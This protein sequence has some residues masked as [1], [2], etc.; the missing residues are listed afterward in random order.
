M[1]FDNGSD[2][3]QGNAASPRPTSPNEEVWCA[4]EISEQMILLVRDRGYEGYSMQEE[5]IMVYGE[6]GPAVEG[7]D[8]DEL[9][10]EMV[11]CVMDVA[12]AFAIISW[13]WEEEAEADDEEIEGEV[14]DIDS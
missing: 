13:M 7:M 3:W 1:A 4:I 14:V 8:V 2:L 11:A 10:W 6:R 12:M 5:V 9:E